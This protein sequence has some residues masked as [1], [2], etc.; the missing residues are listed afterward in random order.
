MFSIHEILPQILE[1][2]GDNI[3]TDVQ[4]KKGLAEVSGR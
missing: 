2:W 4:A 1:L 3:A